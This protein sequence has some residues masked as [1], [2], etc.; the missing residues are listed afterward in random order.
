MIFNFSQ[1][2][3]LDLLDLLDL[4]DEVLEYYYLNTDCLD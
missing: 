1:N 4:L 2:T 3:V